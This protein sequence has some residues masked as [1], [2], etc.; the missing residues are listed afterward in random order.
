MNVSASALNDMAVHLTG[1]SARSKATSTERC[2]KH[3]YAVGHTCLPV[4]A[5]MPASALVKELNKLF[6]QPQRLIVDGVAVPLPAWH[7]GP[8]AIE[9]FAGGLDQLNAWPHNAWWIGCGVAGSRVILFVARRALLAADALPDD[10]S[11][12]ERL[13]ALTDRNSAGPYAVD[14]VSVEDR[15]GTAL[16][17]DYKEFVA[18][19]GPGLFGYDANLSWLNVH[20]PDA[21][22]E[23]WDLFYN[24]SWMSAYAAVNPVNRW[25]QF[26]LFPDPGGLLL[27]A[28]TERGH[29][30]FWL[31]EGRD[32]NRWPILAHNRD[33]L[34]WHRFDGT[35]VEWVVGLLTDPAQEF[36]EAD[37]I[38]RP[39]F[40]E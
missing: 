17:A 38:D 13:V 3:G 10:A 29:R 40:G 27:W 25:Q 37:R 31:T 30:F 2:R 12:V 22:F 1:R 21:D 15:L 4:P 35:A 18:A 14:W 34:R 7:S 8:A 32:P 39:W 11:L 5:G 6:G 33:D 36:S 24:V 28:S 23:S 26:G 19:F 9:V 16:P 20:V